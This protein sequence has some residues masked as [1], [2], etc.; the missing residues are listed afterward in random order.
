MRIMEHP[1]EYFGYFLSSNR[2]KRKAKEIN[3][4]CIR[5]EHSEF[6]SANLYLCLHIT[7]KQVPVSAS[8]VL[9]LYIYH[10]G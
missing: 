6:N 1:G 10:C 2:L 4:T 5:I 3:Q 7:H 8:H 9:Q